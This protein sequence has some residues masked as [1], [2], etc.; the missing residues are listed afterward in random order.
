VL[1]KGDLVRGTKPWNEG[2]ILGIVLMQKDVSS[3][4]DVTS[5]KVHWVNSSHN[6]M[7][8]QPS[9]ITWEVESSVEKIQNE[10]Q[11]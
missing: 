6:K 4:S 8:Q 10:H 5:F 1:E 9:Y 2:T 3:L 7:T 11:R